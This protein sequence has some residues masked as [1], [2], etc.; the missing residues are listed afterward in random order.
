MF[1]NRGNNKE[2]TSMELKTETVK[3]ISGKNSASPLKVS[4]KLTNL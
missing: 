4:I 2:Q 1:I 3:K